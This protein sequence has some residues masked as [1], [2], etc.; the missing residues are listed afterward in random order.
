MKRNVARLIAAI[1]LAAL[2]PLGARAEEAAAPS[3]EE[4]LAELLG[5]ILASED[6]GHNPFEAGAVPD[7]VLLGSSNVAGEVAPCG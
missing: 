4:E 2:A 6:E 5:E 7:L 1:A 3:L